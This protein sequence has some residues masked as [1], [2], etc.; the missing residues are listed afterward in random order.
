MNSGTYV[1]RPLN[2]IIKTYVGHLTGHIQRTSSILHPC[3]PY[4]HTVRD[5]LGLSGKLGLVNNVEVHGAPCQMASTT[6]VAGGAL[7]TQ[8][9]NEMERNVN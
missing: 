2:T 1:T 4:E 9:L 6:L 3:L 8:A 7:A 5:F